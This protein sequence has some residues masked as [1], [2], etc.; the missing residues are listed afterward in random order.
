MSDTF[1]VERSEKIDAPAERVFSQMIDFRNWAAWS[2]W[3]A[4]DPGMEKTFSGSES[5]VGAKYAWTGNRKVGEGRME[6]TG[7][8]EPSQ[9]EVA[10]DFLKPFKSSN[11]TT[12]TL[13]PQGDSTNVTWSM[14]G[15]MTLMTKIMGIFKSM[16]KMVGPDFEKGLKNLKA[17]AEKADV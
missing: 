3:D 16:D 13:E 9:I 11:T 1:T 12:F 14:T 10:L 7:A 2:P 5:G 6:I 15:P 4:L 17:V 8:S